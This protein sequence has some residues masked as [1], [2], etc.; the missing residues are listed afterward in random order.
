MHLIKQSMPMLSTE[1]GLATDTRRFRGVLPPV[2]GQAS[3]QIGRDITL[4][5]VWRAIT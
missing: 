5:F 2:T 4:N 1:T 3:D